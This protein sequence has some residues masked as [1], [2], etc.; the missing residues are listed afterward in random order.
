MKIKTISFIVSGGLFCLVVPTTIYAVDPCPLGKICNPLTGV[1]N[2]GDLLEKIAVGVGAVV[3]SLAVLML[4]IAGILFL[5]SAGNPTMLTRAK[6]A[7]TYAIIGAAIA[8]AA[9][10][11]VALLKNIIGA[12]GDGDPQVEEPSLRDSP[13]GE[14]SNP[15]RRFFG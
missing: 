14:P 8:L 13:V 1:N 9:S 10:G 11:L 6:Q 4:I 12:G 2:F 5:I 7:L 15:G 3:A